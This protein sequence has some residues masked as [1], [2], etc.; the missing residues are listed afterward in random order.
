MNN[1]LKPGAS[2]RSSA[3]P[4]ERG[5]D[6]DSRDKASLTGEKAMDHGGEK[7]VKKEPETSQQVER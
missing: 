3:G 2:S 1:S 4:W 5:T 6:L 7:V